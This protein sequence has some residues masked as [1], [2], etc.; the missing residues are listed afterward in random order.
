MIG[1]NLYR[2]RSPPRTS[3]I[4]VDVFSA[5]P[6][7]Y[8]DI[9]GSSEPAPQSMLTLSCN[10]CEHSS[11]RQEKEK[12]SCRYL[13]IFLSQILQYL[14]VIPETSWKQFTMHRFWQETVIS[15]EPHGFMRCIRDV[16]YRH[17]TWHKKT[18]RERESKLC[19]GNPDEVPTSFV[20]LKVQ[21]VVILEYSWL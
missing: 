10:G 21:L 8:S 3:W 11:W 14:A 6:R 4:T 18:E 12:G 2:V 13:R 16:E 5:S 17:I 7:G 9:A 15:E 1:L 19:H 20:W